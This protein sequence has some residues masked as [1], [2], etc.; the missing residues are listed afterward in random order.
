[1]NTQQLCIRAKTLK[2]FCKTDIERMKSL[3]C[4]ELHCPDRELEL[5]FPGLDNLKNLKKVILDV[6]ELLAYEMQNDLENM[7]AQNPKCEFICS[8]ISNF[9]SRPDL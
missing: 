9:H 6:H 1:M 4:I 5:D 2:Y 8:S 3:T 7:K